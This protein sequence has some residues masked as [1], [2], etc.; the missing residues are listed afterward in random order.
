[1]ASSPGSHPVSELMSVTSSPGQTTPL[2]APSRPVFSF[3]QSVVFIQQV[4]Y[5]P[6]GVMESWL[7]L[8]A[9]SARCRPIVCKFL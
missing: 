4:A 3:H 5:Y 7:I 1:M 6:H 2:P 9:S 8:A